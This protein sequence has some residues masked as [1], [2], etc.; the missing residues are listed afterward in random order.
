MEKLKGLGPKSAEM[1]RAAGVHTLEQLT[2]MGSVAAFCKVQH[3]GCKPSLN[4]L[5]GLES[6]ITGV[7][8][9]VIARDHRTSLLWALEDAQK[10]VVR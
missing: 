8:W 4:F 7:D 2:R 1:L 3:A 10:P 9:R 5:W 6:A